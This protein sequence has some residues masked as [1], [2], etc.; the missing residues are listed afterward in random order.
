M[1]VIAWATVGSRTNSTG[2]CT[3]LTEGVAHLVIGHDQPGS[4][5]YFL[6]HRDQDGMSMADSW[7]QTLD[8][9]KLAAEM[10]Y[11]G[12]GSCWQ[13]PDVGEPS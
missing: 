10:D 12:I 6:F 5:G 7:H 4:G 11:P 2:R 8:E 1:P 3:D 13:E 9:A